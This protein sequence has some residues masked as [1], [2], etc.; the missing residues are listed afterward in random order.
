MSQ[1]SQKS[2][3]KQ[4]KSATPKVEKPFSP[5]VITN[6]LN[7]YYRNLAMKHPNEQN[8]SFTVAPP[9]KELTAQQLSIDLSTY[10]GLKVFNDTYKLVVKQ[11]NELEDPEQVKKAMKDVMDRTIDITF[12]MKL[13]ACL[14]NARVYKTNDKTKINTFQEFIIPQLGFDT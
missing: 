10:E 7:N 11:A 1:R 8:V 3:A 9:D 12:D 13:R 6:F 2:S 5:T 4:T 14:D